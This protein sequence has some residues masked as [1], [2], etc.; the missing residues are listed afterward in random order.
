MSN[1]KFIEAQFGTFKVKDLFSDAFRKDNGEV[2]S[3]KE[4]KRQLKEIIRTEDK[5]NPFTDE[6]IAELLGREEYHISRRTVAKY[7]QK[8]KI[9]TAKLRRTL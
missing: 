4:I 1:S 7:R 6:K 5:T 3:T 9:E 2:I 8:L